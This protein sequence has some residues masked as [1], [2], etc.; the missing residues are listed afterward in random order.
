VLGIIEL[1]V[2]PHVVLIA[3]QETRSP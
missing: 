2:I 3:I 1:E